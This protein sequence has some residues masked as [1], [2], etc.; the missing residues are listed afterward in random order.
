MEGAERERLLAVKRRQVFLAEVL[1]EAQS[2]MPALE[3]A[4][5][6]SP[7]SATVVPDA[8]LSVVPRSAYV[9]PSPPGL[10]ALWGRRQ[11]EAE[12]FGSTRGSTSPQAFPGPRNHRQ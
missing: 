10:W 2:L 1:A 11:R 5:D 8:G 7:P 6:A 9:Q 4:R 3:A 12:L